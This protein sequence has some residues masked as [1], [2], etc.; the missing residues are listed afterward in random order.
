MISIDLK[1]ANRPLKNFWSHIHFHPTDAIEDDWGKE[2]LDEIA[3]NKAA[4]TVR[5]YNM[6]EDIVTRAE[7]GSFLYDFTLNDQRLEY[8]IAKG[9]DIIL[10]YTFIPPCI[11][12][13]PEITS[14]VT[15]SAK[16]YKGKVIVTSP[17]ENYG[18]WEE[19]CFKYTEHIVEKF[20]IETVSKWRLQCYNEPDVK[21]FFMHDLD[22]SAEN[23][24]KR[25]EAYCKLYEAF[26]NGVKRVSEKLLIGGPVLAGKAEFLDG[27][28]K[29]TKENGIPLDFVD[30][31]HYG[32]NPNALNSGRK[33]YFAAANVET[34][35]AFIKI[36]RKYYDGIE[37][38]VS[39]WGMAT[40]GYYNIE[41]CPL[42]LL[43]D[44]SSFAAYF[45]KMVYL[46]IMRKVPVSK[47]LI[48]LSGQHEMRSDFSGCRSFFTLNHIKKPIYN[49]YVLMNRLKNTLCFGASDVEGLNVIPTVDDGGSAAIILAYAADNFMHELPKISESVKIKGV[50]GKVRINTY[51]IDREHT[52]PY[53]TFKYSGFTEP[54]RPYETAALRSAGELKEILSFNTE[55]DGELRVPVSFTSDALVL[56]EINKL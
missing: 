50:F 6:L 10:G 8:L 4:N 22:E 52:N 49:A 55:C 56:I 30:Y 20:G 47:M 21:G 18:E 23:T 32:T 33:P 48:C 54:L 46:F 9:F 44:T 29:F 42:F 31:H 17:P 12:S 13:D 15:K 1:K 35:E 19:I 14:T 5:L 27:F 34:S 3:A 11:A 25:L 7:D 16:R 2:I 28:L 37:I 38:I 43:R 51:V 45:G 41:D 26:A 53:E 36:I 40:A 24:D 39:E